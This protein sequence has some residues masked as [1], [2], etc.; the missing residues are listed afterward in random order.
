MA[1]EYFLPAKAGGSLKRAAIEY[2]RVGDEQRRSIVSEARYSVIEAT[3]FDNYDGGSTG[4]TLVLYLPEA[5]FKGIP[6]S[7]QSELS[8]SICGNLNES[9]ATAFHEYW[10]NVALSM[11]DE[12]DPDYQ[13]A[14][15]PLQQMPPKP[16]AMTFWQPGEIRLFISHRD[17]HKRSAFL[18]AE[19]L[20]EFGVSCFVAHDTIQATKEWRREIMN[21]LETMEAMLVFLTSDFAESPYT[22]QEVGFALGR[23]VPILSVKLE[24][25]DPPAFINHEQALRG[26][27]SDPAASATQILG[28]LTQKLGREDRIQTAAISSF[29]N[30]PSWSDVTPRFNRMNTLVKKLSDGELATIIRGFKSNSQLATAVYLNN[31]YNRLVG[32]LKRTTGRDFEVDGSTIRELKDDDDIPF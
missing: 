3:D 16:E 11:E 2:E 19:A 4:H 29:V 22:N 20:A 10:S 31:K 8:R 32:F 13:K 1:T 30:S 28:L 25:K 24:D 21:G 9:N 5:V 12:N 15:A 26:S 23:R 6:L 14:L 17:V 27:L 7:D 18:L